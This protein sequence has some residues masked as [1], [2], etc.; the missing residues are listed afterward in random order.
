MAYDEEV[1]EAG[2]D[3]DDYDIGGNGE[4][5]VGGGTTAAAATRTRTNAHP[6]E[7]G[8]DVIDALI[9]E[10]I[11]PVPGVPDHHHHHAAAPTTSSII[12][13]GG[14]G[15]GSG[16]AAPLPP[17][18]ADG[19]APRPSLLRGGADVLAHYDGVAHGKL[20]A[21]G[22]TLRRSLADNGRV[23]TEANPIFMY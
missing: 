7:V 19:G 20:F 15:T 16:S 14:G 17:R 13:M 5:G 4:G 21:L 23:M 12:G 1:E 10:R 11:V 6:A 9:E 8:R 2:A 3:D 22:K 18:P